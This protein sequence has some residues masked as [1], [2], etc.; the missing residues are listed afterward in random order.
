MAPW[1]NELDL[2]LASIRNANL[3]HPDD[4]LLECFLH[5]SIE[6]GLTARYVLQR[7]SGIDGHLVIFEV[8][9]HQQPDTKIVAGVKHRD[10]GQCCI[11][12][13]GSSVCDP[14]VVA[15]IIP[16]EMQVHERLHEILGV[17]AGPQLQH[18][19]TSNGA[20][21]DAYANHW[22]VRKSAALALA[23]G[24]FQLII[25][26]GPH[27][28]V[29][30]VDIGG[31]ILPPIVDEMPVIRN[32]S[33]VDHS[34]SGIAIPDTSSL[35]VLSR[36][37]NSIRWSFVGQEIAN[38][39]PRSPTRSPI[40]SPQQ[41]LPGRVATILIKTWSAVPTNV[42]I[43]SYQLLAFL[44]ARLYG[45]SCSLKVQQLPF[46]MYL[47][48][49]GVER[50]EA[51]ANE[52][53]ALQ[54]A[55]RHSGIPVPR[56]L[57]LVSNSAKSYL[58]TS[59]APGLRLGLCIDTLSDQELAIM[60]RD[61]R[62]CVG[63]LRSIPKQV[64][65]NH[66]ICNALGKACCDNRINAALDYGEDRGDFVGPFLDEEELNKMLQTPA[67]PGVSHR[68]GHKIVF[69][70]ADL[71]MRNVL[72]RNGRLSAIVDCENSGW[73][74]EYW[75]YTKAHYITRLQRRWLRVVDEVFKEY[76]GYE[77]ELAT[78]RELWHYCF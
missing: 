45:P 60:A 38:K 48:T 67:F 14:L 72:V 39:Q 65:P 32:A 49:S 2:V 8:P 41:L 15:P 54:L 19:I 7:C 12:G 16:A 25:Q 73:Y 13:F 68:G 44:G 64:A 28:E 21:L 24:F 34:A 47:K 29:V 5:D 9:S 61:L 56:P 33:F 52:Y 51:L 31:P 10:G 17:F 18:H 70:H 53:G 66:A 75:D 20:S 74:P 30:V 76:G 46:G 1:V 37:A 62:T 43:M 3:S 27:Y 23:Q 55:R 6:P 4:Q 77:G 58:L 69:T 42:R 59:E 50:H 57:D 63:Q 22:L 40:K 71:N 78:E 11:T 35:Q 26:E 36:F